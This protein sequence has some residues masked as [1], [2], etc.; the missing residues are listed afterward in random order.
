MLRHMV[1]FVILKLRCV[2]TDEY[3]RVEGSD[4]SIF[5]FGDAATIHSPMAA[6]HVDELFVAADAD[7][8]GMLTVSELQQ[9]L[10]NCEAEF[11]HLAKHARFLDGK[12]NR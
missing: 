2:L 10:H 8:D 4:G 9:L 11:P 6:E 12:Q 5:V 3:M 7:K 1:L